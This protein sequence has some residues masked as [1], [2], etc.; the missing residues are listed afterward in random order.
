MALAIVVGAQIFNVFV[1]ISGVPQA[2]VNWLTGMNLSQFSVIII[3]MIVYFIMGIPMNGLTIILLTL[4]ILLPVL[5]A[6]HINLLWFGVLAIIQC[7]LANLSPPVGMDLYVVAQMAKPYGITMTDVFWGATPF[8]LTCM[9]V[10]FLLI[11]FPSISLFLVSL[12]N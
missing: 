6:Y 5:E 2:L 1:A 9:V 11:I 10:N 3:I 4:P 7:E 8:C 12:M